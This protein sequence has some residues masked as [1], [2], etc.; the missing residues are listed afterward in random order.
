M[1]LFMRRFACCIALIPA[2][3]CARVSSKLEEAEN[4]ELPYDIWYTGTFL[5]AT[6]VNLTAIEPF[7][8]FYG[9]YGDYDSDWKVKSAK[10]TTWSI[11][12]SVE[13]LL[14]LTHKLSVEFLGG[15]LS[16]FKGGEKATH[17]TDTI[18]I[19]GYEISTDKKNT[20]IPN[21]RLGFQTTFPTGKYDRLDPK[22]KGIEVSGQGAYFF[23]PLLSFSK[24]FRLP[25]HFFNLYWSAGYFIP[26]YAYVKGL[27]DYGGGRGT[28]GKIRPGRLLQA[29]LSGEYSLANHWVFGFDL[30]LLYL[31]KT[32]HFKGRRGESLPGVAAH[33]GL[34]S[35]ITISVAPQLE[36]N[37]TS[38]SGI[39]FGAWCTVAGRNTKAF[40]SAFFA[41]LYVF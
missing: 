27:N 5:S 33:V 13:L 29:G 9:F 26:T 38:T 15:F 25:C 32:S 39:L 36:Y 21:C 37:F 10:E 4:E 34:P 22:K 17:I 6:A 23:G 28:K 31:S 35:S 7:I 2:L 20:P 11:N 24:T 41:Y 12:P 30:E 1:I 18:V 3:L 40:A 19:L 8:T 14:K 16:N